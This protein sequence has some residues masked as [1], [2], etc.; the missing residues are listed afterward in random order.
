MVNIVAFLRWMA[1]TG[2]ACFPVNTLPSCAVVLLDDVGMN[3]F[4][5]IFIVNTQLGL[6]KK[7]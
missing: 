3:P 7:T 5:L 6:S 4:T 1:S 2:L